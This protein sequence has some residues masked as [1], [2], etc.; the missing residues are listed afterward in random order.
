M[1]VLQM[2]EMYFRLIGGMATF[3]ADIDL[4]PS[5]FMAIGMLHA[6]YFESVG[7]QRASLSER[8]FAHPTFVWTNS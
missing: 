4:V 8:L 6:V 5:F 3:F 2:Y 7:L 1:F